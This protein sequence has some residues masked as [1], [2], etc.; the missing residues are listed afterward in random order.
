[1]SRVRGLGGSGFPVWRL[2]VGGGRPLLRPE[3]RRVDVSGVSLVLL[4]WLLIASITTVSQ[5]QHWVRADT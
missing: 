3:A 5:Q 4:S 2:S 1:M